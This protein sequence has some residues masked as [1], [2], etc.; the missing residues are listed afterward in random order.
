MIVIRGGASAQL[1]RVCRCR[2]FAQLPPPPPP[3]K[4]LGSFFLARFR[5]RPLYRG[6][7]CV[8]SGVAAVC[9]HS[10]HFPLCTAACIPKLV[11]TP[12][13]SVSPLNNSFIGEGRSHNNCY[14]SLLLQTAWMFLFTRPSFHTL[15]YQSNTKATLLCSHSSFSSIVHPPVTGYALGYASPVPRCL[16]RV[17]SPHK[18]ALITPRPPFDVVFSPWA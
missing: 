8:F 14:E 7:V 15:L 18:L 17:A 13:R 5:V 9:S 4:L 1:L 11:L 12:A 16:P 10:A 6:A 3:L 2:R